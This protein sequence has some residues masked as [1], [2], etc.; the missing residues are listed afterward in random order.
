MPIRN[1]VVVDKRDEVN[2]GR[3]S[4]SGITSNGNA[5]MRLHHV[6]NGPRQRALC[7]LDLVPSRPVRI[8]VH[9]DKA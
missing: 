4:Y 2:I 3:L 7:R 5:R 8:V 6:S 1:L 9:H